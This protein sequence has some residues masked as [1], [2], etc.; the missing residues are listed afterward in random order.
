MTGI[1]WQS[2]SEYQTIPLD[3][4]EDFGSFKRQNVI[5]KTIISF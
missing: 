5:L 3:K 1:T 4:I 2:V